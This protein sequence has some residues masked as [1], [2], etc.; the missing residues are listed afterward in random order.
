MC[1]LR[2][3]VLSRLD[4][5]SLVLTGSNSSL[6][7]SPELSGHYHAVTKQPYMPLGRLP[8]TCCLKV[9]TKKRKANKNKTGCGA[10]PCPPELSYS[11]HNCGCSQ[12]MTHNSAAPAYNG[13]VHRPGTGA[14]V[15]VCVFPWAQLPEKMLVL[16]FKSVLHFTKVLW[17]FLSC[18]QPDNRCISSST[19]NQVILSAENCSCRWLRTPWPSLPAGNMIVELVAAAKTVFIPSWPLLQH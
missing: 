9:N 8:L 1:L 2:I 7:P 3:N 16:A 11:D 17:K 6:S 15:P 13:A 5:V 12:E 10:K 14:F 4:Q 18:K 19:E